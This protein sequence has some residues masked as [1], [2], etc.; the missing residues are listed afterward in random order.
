M[1]H[2]FTSYAYDGHLWS[3]CEIV[4]NECLHPEALE[5]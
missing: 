2:E 4:Q 1:N 5:G 3:Q